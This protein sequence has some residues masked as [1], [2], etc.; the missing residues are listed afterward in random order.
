MT[1]RLQP[2]ST[3]RS[4]GP[5]L[6]PLVAAGSQHSPSLP[7]LHHAGSTTGRPSAHGSAR[8][9]E[10]PEA[11][12]PLTFGNSFQREKRPS[13]K[14]DDLRHSPALQHAGA[15]QKG[16]VDDLARMCQD[17]GVTTVA[18]MVETQDQLDYLIDIG[19]DKAQGWL[20]GKPAKKPEYS[21]R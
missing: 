9:F 10:L 20:F 17:L 3:W 2:A 18:E 14:R 15:A 12:A 4:L 6:Q 7:L 5:P 21:G 16:S 19:V 13:L 11:A 8:K 1:E